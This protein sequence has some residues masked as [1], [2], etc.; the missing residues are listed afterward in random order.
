MS[1]GIGLLGGLMALVL[2]LST[3]RY[4]GA[5]KSGSASEKTRSTETAADRRSS[6]VSDRALA[7]GALPA[8]ALDE[9]MRAVQRGELERGIDVLK[10]ARDRETGST[11]AIDSLIDSLRRLRSNRLP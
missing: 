4:F 11:V 6:V 9:A 1:L 7:P 8:L 10:K 3:M 2:I 5:G